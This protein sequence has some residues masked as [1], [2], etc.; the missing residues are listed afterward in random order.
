MRSAT[1]SCAALRRPAGVLSRSAMYFAT[2]SMLRS[3]SAGIDATAG[4][5]VAASG[6]GPGG[7]VGTGAV[8]EGRGAVDAAGAGGGTG[9]ADD[10][11]RGGGG[12]SSPFFFAKRSS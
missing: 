7:A 6:H 12:G 4:W 8:P 3:A 5:S 10:E 9:A 11:G 2:D 1:Q